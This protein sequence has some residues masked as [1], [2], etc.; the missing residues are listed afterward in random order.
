M[1]RRLEARAQAPEL[2]DDLAQGGAELR[3]ALRHLRRL[4]RLFAASGRTLYGVARL[5]EQAGRP[6]RL[7][8]LDIGAGSGDVNAA[9][10]RWADARGVAI[11][12]TL[13]DRTEEACAEARAFYAGEPRVTV[14]RRDLFALEEDAADIVTASQFI[15]HFG[16]EELPDVTRAMLKASKMGVVIQDIHRHWLAWTAVWLAA[17]IVSGNRFVVNDGP[18]SVA[19]GFRAADWERLRLRLDASG[20][21]Y[22]WRPLFRYVVTVPKT[23]A[24]KTTLHGK[25]GGPA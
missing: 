19:K 25:G 23:V 8:V 7:T 12:I 10:L 5:W 9:L 2:M 15:H 20:M 3:E 18:L 14:V 17:R 16:D 1:F 13:A 24:A 11:G 22:S 4:N 21:A 6:K